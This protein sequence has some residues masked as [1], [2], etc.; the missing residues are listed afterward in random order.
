MSLPR[1]ALLR[2]RHEG[3][4]KRPAVLAPGGGAVRPTPDPSPKLYYDY[5]VYEL[6]L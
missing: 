6:K 2:L 1:P 3:M 4:P 5:Y